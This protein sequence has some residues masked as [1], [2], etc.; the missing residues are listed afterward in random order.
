MH[1]TQENLL[2]QR[3][4]ELNRLM[5]PRP[6]AAVDV[7]MQMKPVC[8]NVNGPKLSGQLELYDADM[9]DLYFTRH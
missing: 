3:R 1:K 7:R 8:W 5:N 9:A 4:S 6:A 2:L